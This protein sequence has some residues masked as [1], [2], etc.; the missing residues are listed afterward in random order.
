MLIKRIDNTTLERC[1][2]LANQ[3]GSIFNSPEWTSIYQKNFLKYGI[4]D[5]DNKL[6][7]G[8]QLYHEKR[9]LLNFYRNPPYS[10]HIGL[11][12]EN[13]SQNKSSRLS[14]E[15]SIIQLISEFISK[16]PYQ[17]LSIALPPE[18]SDTQ[19]FFWNHF[20]V[21]PNYTYRLDLSLPVEELNKLM[22]PERRNDI[23]RA[24]KD[25]IEVKKINDFKIIKEI[26]LH[27][28]QRNK[29]GIDESF[30]DSILFN[31]ANESNS[32][33]FT[34]YH[35]QQALACS[36]CIFDAN[37]AYY[38]LGGY[39]NNNPH[40]G[41]GAL[42]ISESIKFAK[43]SGKNIFDFEGSMLKPVEKYFRGFG[44]ELKPYFTVNKANFLVEIMLKF[45]KR[46]SF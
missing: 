9:A 40:K 28:F 18:F 31:F 42:C 14:F 2:Q 26:I 17:I 20:K 13:K 7:G 5:N 1:H 29:K 43:E 15:K 4:F 21:I 24:I 12:F 27:T 30:I 36:L 6:I 41:A 46:E 35:K 23:S 3:L 16:L 10:P 33:A 37:T 38:I 22:A 32:Y 11:F 44:G 19:P 39:I 25:G 45:V 8:F 34:A